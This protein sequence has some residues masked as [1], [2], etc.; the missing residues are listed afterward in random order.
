MLRDAAVTTPTLEDLERLAGQIKDA[1]Y[2]VFVA[3]GEI[4][5]ISHAL[6]LHDTDPFVLF[7][8]LRQ[9]GPNETL[10]KNLDPAHAFYLG[11]EMCKA[12]TAMTLAKQYTQDEALDWGLLTRPEER[13]YLKRQSNNEREVE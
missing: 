1:N 6:H 7:E 13:H 12:A 5:V 2:R 9:S 4:H 8:K 11:Y 3:N 10:P